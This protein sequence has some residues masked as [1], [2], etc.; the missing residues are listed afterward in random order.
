MTEKSIHFKKAPIVEAVLAFEIET[1]PAE[2]LPHLADF[3]AQT[4]DSYGERSEV[5]AHQVKFGAEGVSD[6][7]SRVLGYRFRS[8]DNRHVVQVRLNGF[9]FSRLNPYDCWEGFRDEARR[10]WDLY[11][12]IVP[13]GAIQVFGT[14]YINQ[15]LVPSAQPIDRYLKVYPYIADELPQQ[16]PLAFVRLQLFIPEPQGELTIQVQTV[17]SGVVGK[18]A[19]ILDN[20]LRFPGVGLSEEAIWTRLEEARKLKNAYFLAEITEEMKGLIS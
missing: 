8:K 13:F 17:R 10:L 12:R 19:Y 4:G 5:R 3:A 14:R 11:R 1:Q 6:A 20:D 7:D 2:L 9:A 15:L 16:G 18:D